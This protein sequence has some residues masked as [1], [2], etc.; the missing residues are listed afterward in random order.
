M[1]G[2]SDTPK[3][4]RERAEEARVLAD[5]MKHPEARRQMLGIAESCDRIAERVELGMAGRP[6]GRSDAPPQPGED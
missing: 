4:W 6:S 5:D 3:H 2:R 1:P